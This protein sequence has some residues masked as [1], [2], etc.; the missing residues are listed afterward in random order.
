L[1]DRNDKDSSASSTDANT[2]TSTAEDDDKITRQ[3]QRYSLSAK[4]P[5][6]VHIRKRLRKSKGDRVRIGILQDHEE[7]H[8][9]NGGPI[10]EAVLL[11]DPTTSTNASPIRL[12]VLPDTLRPPPSRPRLR[13]LLGIPYP[14]VIQQLWAVLT[15][16]MVE[17]IVYCPSTLTDL[18]YLKSSSLTPAKY[19]PLIREGLAQAEDTQAPKVFVLRDTTMLQ[20]IQDTTSRLPSSATATT[21][22]DASTETTTSTSCSKFNVNVNLMQQAAQG[23][24]KIVLH[25]GNYPSLRQCYT[26]FVKQQQQTIDPATNIMGMPPP[27]GI[28]LAIGPERGWTD[29]EVEAFQSTNFMVASLGSPILR[30]DTAI[31]SGVALA[32]D[33]LLE[34]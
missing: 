28:L 11:N 32:R 25:I 1:L 33:V 18:E 26:S 14:K 31:V 12:Q 16:F 27:P 23:C 17:E 9:N 5:R 22:T 19:L 34:K 8:Q 6:S 10:G 30:T 20:A 3:D 7:D 21:K 15:S 4:D 13:L 29:E 2:C 24:C